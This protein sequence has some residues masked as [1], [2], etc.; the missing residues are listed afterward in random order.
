MNIKG[1]RK[2]LEF[3]KKNKILYKTKKTL[4]GNFLVI[5]GHYLDDAIFQKIEKE[6]KEKERKKEKKRLEK[7]LKMLAI[8]DAFTL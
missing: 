3:C 1:K 6:L 4:K 5:E 8:Q 7:R 2:I